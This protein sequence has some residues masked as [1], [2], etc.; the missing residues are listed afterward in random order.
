MCYCL[1]IEAFTISGEF[2]GKVID[3]VKKMQQPSLNKQ[4][5]HV[6]LSL[7]M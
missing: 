6:N 5:F 1:L 3:I 4:F 2:G 7:F